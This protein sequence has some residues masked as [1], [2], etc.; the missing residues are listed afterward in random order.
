MLQ[1]AIA[2][3]LAGYAIAIPVGAIAVLIIH[4][5][6]SHGLRTGIAAAAGAASA[7]LLYAS[8]AAL[9]GLWVT[10]LI[11]PLI[12]PLR[13][14]GG[15]ILIALGLRGL[16]TLRSARESINPIAAHDEARRPHHRTYLALLAL[17]LLNPATVV[18]F[19]ALTIGLP[20]LGGLGERLVFAVA[21]GFASL[22]WQLLLATV[23]A[24]LGRGG[25]HRVRYWSAAIGNGVIVVL[26]ALIAFSALG[27]PS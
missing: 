14:V 5:G 6:L 18:Y 21:A 3:L 9:A 8:I 7:D 2:G 1:A 16:M 23:G 25:G 24:A 4:T 15:A 27:A 13:V 11:G 12:G 26:G 10:S 17:T 19:T 20:F 22:S